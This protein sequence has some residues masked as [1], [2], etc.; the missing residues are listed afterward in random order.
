MEE[1]WRRRG[2]G[3]GRVA[4]C[5]LSR[6]HTSGGATQGYGL[7]LAVVITPYVK[8]G[9]GIL[10]DLWLPVI[11]EVVRAAV[12]MAVG[13]VGGGGAGEGA[14]EVEEAQ[15]CRGDEEDR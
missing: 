1:K 13:G 5:W 6:G 4:R 2:D 3:G 12:G 10:G 7:T 8:L 14:H 9:L 11:E 15:S